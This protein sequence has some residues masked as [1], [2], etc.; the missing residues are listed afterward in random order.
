[1]NSHSKSETTRT[2]ITHV[3]VDVSKHHLDVHIPGR[4][5]R[6]DPN[7]EAGIAALIGVL[8]SLPHPR[9]I[10]EATGGYEHCLATSVLHAGL[11]V[12]IVQP[13]RVRH[14]ALAEGLLAKTDRIDAALLSRFGEKLQPRCEVAPDPDAVRLREMLE[15]RRVI[16]DLVSETGNRLEL[17]RGYLREHLEAQLAGF[18]ATLEGVESDIANHLK[19]SPVLS[20]RAARLQELKGAGPVLAAT[21]LAYVPELGKV[22]DKTLASLVGVAPHPRD[23][24]M[25]SRT[26]RVRGG[27]AVVRHV[28]YMAAVSA[29]RYNEVLKAFYQRLRHEKG[30]PAKLALVAVM[31]KM[32]GVLNRLLA[33]PQFTL[34]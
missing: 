30:K 32:L 25:T 17:A 21:L 9:V 6:R 7:T 11:E 14:L 28:L 1:M 33:D 27:R 20:A 10:C 16:V 13:A 19:S 29:A 34:A 12:C 23:S 2:E 26:R 31:R 24:G 3:G 18:K 22:G 4:P 8:E 15:M 5:A